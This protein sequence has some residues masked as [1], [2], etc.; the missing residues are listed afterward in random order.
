ML[1][2]ARREFDDA[3]RSGLDAFARVAV[4]GLF[5]LAVLYTLSIARDIFLPI[6]L[7][8]FLS[9][10]FRPVVRRLKRLGI[11]TPLSA[12]VILVFTLG[13]FALAVNMLRE[14]AAEWLERAPH[15]LH[16]IEQRLAPLKQT[17][18]QAREASEDLQRVAQGS[19]PPAQKVVVETVPFVQRIIGFTATTVVQAV[20]TITLFLFLLAQGSVAVSGSLARLLSLR[21][22][23]IIERAVE[24]VEARVSTY[25]LALAII[26][27]GVGVCTALA[28]LALGAP[29]PLLWG[30]LAALLGPMPYV[31]PMLTVMILIAMGATAYQNAWMMFAP[32]A[33]YLVI[34]QIE[35]EF[36]TPLVQGRALKLSP[37]A[38]FLSIML[39]TWM[40]GALG[41][42]LAVP[43][44]VVATAVLEHVT[45][46]SSGT[47]AGANLVPA[48]AQD[49]EA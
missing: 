3:P 41:A 20:A 1:P 23:A 13:I 49:A 21:H 14:P 22:V 33:A 17:I 38:V 4:V 18:D 8:V 48:A 25:L 32:A 2:A 12:L 39:W 31:G 43:I 45:K 37:V 44:L 47:L 16:A 40:W 35:A 42:L 29:N 26:N 10:V 6:F 28:M 30:V 24:D 34:N 46:P 15:T 7:A 5:A 27:L 9:V 11:P 19:H 36:V